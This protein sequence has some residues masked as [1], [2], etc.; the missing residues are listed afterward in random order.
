MLKVKNV[1]K[2]KQSNLKIRYAYLQTVVKYMY[3]FNG[4]GI[5]L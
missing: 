3:S 1:K 2:V 4:N 5:K